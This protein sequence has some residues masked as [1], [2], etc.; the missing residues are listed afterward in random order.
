MTLLL[1]VFLN[2]LTFF[3]GCVNV[4]FSCDC[5][6]LGRRT[7][8]GQATVMPVQQSITASNGLAAMLQ[9]RQSTMVVGTWRQHATNRSAVVMTAKPKTRAPEAFGQA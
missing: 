9:T 6:R 1:L 8:L 2:E 3:N 7:V 5:H 4:L